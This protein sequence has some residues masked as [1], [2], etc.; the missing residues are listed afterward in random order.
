MGYALEQ[1][2]V[3]K[4]RITIDWGSQALS[5]TEQ[6]YSITE[7]ELLAVVKGIKH[8]DCYLRGRRFTVITD[9]RALEA[10]NLKGGLGSARLERLREKLQEYNFNVAYVEG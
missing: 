8:H 2:N 6:R 1:L 3:N 7:K 5:K 10:L 9:H 4:E